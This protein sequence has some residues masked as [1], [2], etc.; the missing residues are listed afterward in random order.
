MGFNELVTVDGGFK[1]G[2][3]VD[4]GVVGMKEYDVEIVGE[5]VITFVGFNE[6]T[7]IVVDGLGVFDDTLVGVEGDTEL[8]GFNELVIIE[9]VVEIGKSDIEL[10][11]VIRFVGFNELIGVVDGLGVID[12]K[13]VDNE[14]DIEL[15][16]L[17]EIDV[18][19]DVVEIG[20]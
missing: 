5:G 7:A 4:D 10:V 9:A 18:V 8:E 6:L 17:H 12:V 15:E 2:I 13:L 16:G 19:E 1:D 20:K 14:G 11:V 3:V